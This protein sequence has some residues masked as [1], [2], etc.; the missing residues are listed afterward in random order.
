MSPLML[1]Y[2]MKI[3]THTVKKEACRRGRHNNHS[4]LHSSYGE[5]Q[6]TY[7]KDHDDFS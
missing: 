2:I 3:I 4:E 7:N 6:T 5:Q 1:N